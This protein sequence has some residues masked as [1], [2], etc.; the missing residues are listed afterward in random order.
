MNCFNNSF[1]LFMIFRKFSLDYGWSMLLYIIILLRIKLWNVW[2]IISFK[3]LIMDIFYFKWLLLNKLAIWRLISHILEMLNSQI[4][5]SHNGGY[6]SF[7]R[8]FAKAIWGWQFGQGWVI[9]LSITKL[10][11]FVKLTL[12]IY[13]IKLYIL[14]I[15]VNSRSNAFNQV[16]QFYLSF[17]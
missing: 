6:S 14:F 12:C 1:F 9:S 2:R 17:R 8:S 5:R 7:T 4:K 11:W 3:K 10:S 13:T 15:N 16:I